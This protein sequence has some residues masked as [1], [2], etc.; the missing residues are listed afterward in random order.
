MS[1]TKIGERSVMKDDVAFRYFG[2][3]NMKFM[4]FVILMGIPAVFY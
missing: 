4:E 3:R 1:E 2:K